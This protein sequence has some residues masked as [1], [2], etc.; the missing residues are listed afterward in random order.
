MMIFLWETS[1]PIQLGGLVGDASLSLTPTLE[2][3]LCLAN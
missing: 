2:V 1:F 3:A